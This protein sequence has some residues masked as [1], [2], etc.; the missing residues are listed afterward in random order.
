MI[1]PRRWYTPARRGPGGGSLR[2]STC[3]AI[4]T[5]LSTS[6][7]PLRSRMSPRGAGTTTSRMRLLFACARYL[8]PERTW[9]NHR[10]K[11]MIANIVSA[12]PPRIA[13]RRASCGVI[14]GRRSSG[15]WSWSISRCSI[16][17]PR[18]HGGAPDRAGQGSR[19]QPLPAAK[20]SPMTQIQRRDCASSVVVGVGGRA[21]LCPRDRAE[22]AGGVGA[23]PAA[24]RVVGQQRKQ[25]APDDAVDR[26]GDDRVDRDRDEYVAKQQPA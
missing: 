26:Q 8:S 3:T 19:A 25:E 11:K 7:L 23:P 18:G 9:R 13:T 21:S 2:A 5:R 12:I 24:A 14:G 20:A 10:R 17:G 22:P 6:T 16:P 1:C 4:D 15:S